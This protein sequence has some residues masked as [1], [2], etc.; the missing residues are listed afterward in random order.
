MKKIILSLI[1]VFNIV[2]LFS[3]TVVEKQYDPIYW[4]SNEYH[5][6]YSQNPN[7][8]PT[9]TAFNETVKDVILRVDRDEEGYQYQV[10]L[11]DLED[12]EIYLEILEVEPNDYVTESKNNEIPNPDLTMKLKYNDEI[13][14]SI[15]R[16]LKRQSD[17]EKDSLN[18]DGFTMGGVSGYLFPFWYYQAGYL[19]DG[20][21]N[22]VNDNSGI[23]E[24]IDEYLSTKKE[25]YL[26]REYNS[27]D[28]ILDN[29]VFKDYQLKVTK[30]EIDNDTNISSI[31]ASTE[32][33]RLYGYS[34]YNLELKGIANDDTVTNIGIYRINRDLTL[35]TIDNIYRYEWSNHLD[36]GYHRDSG[37]ID[38]Q[39]W[40]YPY[41]NSENERCFGAFII[42][43]IYNS[44]FHKCNY[45]IFDMN[46]TFEY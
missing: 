11:I 7:T 22:T 38:I 31:M 13:F 28:L 43:N 20:V 12:N 34:F 41:Y 26:H 23:M 4:Y 16:H 37:K 21:Y 27:D 45:L 14:D 44:E 30:I 10:S 46:Q 42:L 32:S 3:C 15:F 9:F 40:N 8:N 1:I 35:D 29:S 2:F 18:Y 33:V 19:T 17:L 36:D 5:L 24:V 25:S 39:L 6:K